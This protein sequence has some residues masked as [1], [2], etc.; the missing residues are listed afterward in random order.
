MNFQHL[1]YEVYDKSDNLLIEFCLFE[2]KALIHENLSLKIN[3]F[4]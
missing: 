3:R 2:E 1:S 4:L